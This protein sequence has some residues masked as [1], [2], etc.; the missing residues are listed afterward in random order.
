MESVG[1][2]GWGMRV[3]VGIWTD[4]RRV[5][6]MKA[7]CMVVVDGDGF[8]GGWI[9][10]VGYMRVWHHGAEVYGWIRVWDWFRVRH[11]AVGMRCDRDFGLGCVMGPGWVEDLGVCRGL[12][13]LAANKS[14]GGGWRII[15]GFVLLCW[16]YATSNLRLEAGRVYFN[17]TG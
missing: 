7:G 2:G 5:G 13:G 17:E 4:G 16:G 8:D 15:R 11:L 9:E 1:D 3:G 14:G 6:V 12:E 10:S